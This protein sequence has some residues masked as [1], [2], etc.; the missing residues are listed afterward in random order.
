MLIDMHDDARQ[1]N[2]ARFEQLRQNMEER[3]DRLNERLEEVNEMHRDLSY[4]LG[5]LG[6]ELEE[7]RQVDAALHRDLW[8]LH[9]QRV[10]IRTE[11][12]QEELDAAT[13]QRRDAESELRTG[14]SR[15][16]R[17]RSDAESDI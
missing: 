11:Q 1:E 16:P 8:Y 5:S 4:R 2:D 13:S 6:S 9:E 12:I 14:A 3:F 10:R 15:R 7:L 17:R